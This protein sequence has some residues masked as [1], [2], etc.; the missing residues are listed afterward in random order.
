[1][2]ADPEVPSFAWDSSGRNLGFQVGP[3]KGTKSWERAIA[4]YK[5]RLDEWEW[6]RLAHIFGNVQYLRAA[7]A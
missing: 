4:K 5:S 1:M 2:E 3:S 6:R 7:R